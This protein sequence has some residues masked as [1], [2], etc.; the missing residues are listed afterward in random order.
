MRHLYMYQ[1][2][3]EQGSDTEALLAGAVADLAGTLHDGLALACGHVVRDL[4]GVRAVVHHQQLQILDIGDH[5][6]P[7][8]C[9][10]RGKPLVSS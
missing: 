9:A 8:S 10:Q 1:Q 4:T 3:M 5:E 2:N 7:E 6:L